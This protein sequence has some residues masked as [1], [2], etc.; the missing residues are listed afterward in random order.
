MPNV[1]RW[2][3]SVAT[4]AVAARQPKIVYTRTIE[5]WRAHVVMTGA[6]I[7]ATRPN[8]LQNEIPV[9]LPEGKKE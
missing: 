5:V 1:S 4:I 6:N 7:A 8:E 3:I 2:K 9:A